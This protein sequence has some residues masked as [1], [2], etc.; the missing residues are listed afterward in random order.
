MCWAYSGLLLE[1]EDA[2]QYF[3]VKVLLEAIPWS[4]ALKIWKQKVRT[5]EKAL[6]DAKLLL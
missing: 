5:L 1:K 2:Q 6:V 4:I 3:G